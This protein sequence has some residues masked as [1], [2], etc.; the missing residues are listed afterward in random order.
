M[1]FGS[2]RL[3]LV[4]LSSTRSFVNSDAKHKY[5]ISSSVCASM[6]PW[7]AF[8]EA[9]AEEARTK[10]AVWPLDEHNAKTLNEVHPRDYVQSTT[11]PYEIYDLIAIGAGAGGLVSST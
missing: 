8:D 10:L 7:K 5:H 3:L 11:D 1:K 6:S 4:S 2:I 9:Q